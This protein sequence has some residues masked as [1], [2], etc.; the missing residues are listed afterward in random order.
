MRVRRRGVVT[1]LHLGN[2]ILFAATMLWMLRTL[3]GRA[4]E[5]ALNI[6]LGL[7]L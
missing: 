3:A 2:Y 5:T 4:V 7:I 1:V 6:G